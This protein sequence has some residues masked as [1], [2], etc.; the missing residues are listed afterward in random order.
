MDSTARM[1]GQYSHKECKNTYCSANPKFAPAKKP[2]KLRTS[3]G[4]PK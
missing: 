2:K 1:C 3:V 4:S